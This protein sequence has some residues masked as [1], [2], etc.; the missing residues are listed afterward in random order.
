MAAAR[1]PVRRASWMLAERHAF[2]CDA[3][4]LSGKDHA[5]GGRLAPLPFNSNSTMFTRH[6]WLSINLLAHIEA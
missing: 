1:S 6:N 5:T 2:S 3:N 4:L